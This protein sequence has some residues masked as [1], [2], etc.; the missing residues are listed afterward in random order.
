M[1]GGCFR[2]DPSTASSACRLCGGR[3]R[4]RSSGRG[5]PARDSR[6]VSRRST[7][8]LAYYS[9]A[10]CRGSAVADRAHVD[11]E[12]GGDGTVEAG[13]D[14]IRANLAHGLGDLEVAPLDRGPKL[15]LDGRRDVRGGHRA[16]Q[17]TL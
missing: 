5:S 15:L 7:A 17:P 14:L 4:S 8:M 12:G 9:T 6:S 13:R 11:R 16:V 1:L 3:L 2:T 10:S